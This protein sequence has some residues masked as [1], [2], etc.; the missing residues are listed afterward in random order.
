MFLQNTPKGQLRQEKVSC[1]FL[2]KAPKISDQKSL[3]ASCVAWWNYP[4]FWKNKHI[5]EI[6]VKNGVTDALFKNDIY[7]LFFIIFFITEHS[8]ISGLQKQQIKSKN[9]LFLNDTWDTSYVP[10]FHADFKYVLIFSKFLI[11]SSGSTTCDKR[12]LRAYF[13][14][15]F[16]NYSFPNAFPTI[17]LVRATPD[18][19]Y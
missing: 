11:V 15:L 5:F 6:S 10:I 2:K 16:G 19:S 13:G 17:Y 9:Q 3:T 7:V 1:F 12:F 8:D 4:A 18:T 14:G